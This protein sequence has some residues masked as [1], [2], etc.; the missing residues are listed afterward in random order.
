MANRSTFKMSVETWLRWEGRTRYETRNYKVSLSDLTQDELMNLAP[1][2]HDMIVFAPAMFNAIH[3]RQHPKLKKTIAYLT[4][5]NERQ[6]EAWKVF[7]VQCEQEQDD[8]LRQIIELQDRRHAK[9]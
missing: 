4:E 3:P 8:T 5:L 1:I 2:P 6:Q 7:L 9:V